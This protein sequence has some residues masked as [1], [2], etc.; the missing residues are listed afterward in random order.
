MIAAIMI[1]AIV[2]VTTIILLM[3]RGKLILPARIVWN[4]KSLPA[5]GIGTFILKN[6]K[7]FLEKEDGSTVALLEDGYMIS[8][9]L[10]YD[11]DGDGDEELV[12]LLWKKGRYGK[13]SPFWIK[14]DK[15]K[16]SQHIFIFDIRKD[17]EKILVSKWGTSD[18]GREVRRW[19]VLTDEENRKFKKNPAINT[20]LI[21]D[22]NGEVTLW[23]WE[24]WGLKNYDGSVRFVC[25]GDNLIHKDILE[26]GLYKKKGDFGFLYSNFKKDIAGA[27]IAVLNLESPL[28]DDPEL[29]GGYPSFGSPIEVGKAISDVGFD[30]VNCANNHI[31]DKGFKGVKTT[32]DFFDKEGIVTTGIIKKDKTEDPSG[33]FKEHQDMGTYELITKN[34][35]RIA[36]FNYTYGVNTD[37]AKMFPDKSLEEH[38]YRICDLSLMNKDEIGEE[39]REGR[40]EADVVI[41][42]AHWGDEY[43]T[44]INEMQ[45]EYAGLFNECGADVVVGSHPH[46]LQPFDTIKGKD[47]HETLVYYSLGNFR[48]SQTDGIKRE[49]GE[50]VFT[51]TYTFDGIRVADHDLKKFD[52]YWK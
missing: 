2:C 15:S 48:A 38:P 23:A 9:F 14:D 7:L 52:S 49:G 26:Y 16:W 6:R 4:E 10:I 17:N 34:G 39:L 36:I 50:A 22:V 5:D 3:Y 44:E 31:L 24:S 37:V 35:I 32:L 30:I 18:N 40:N 47:G 1:A 28:V 29:Y 19:R 41:V 20:L 13:S 45:R 12:A 42:F 27:D 51:F 43:N 33:A 8:D 46:V 21:E 11:M 25:F